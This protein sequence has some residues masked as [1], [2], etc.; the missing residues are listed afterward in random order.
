MDDLDLQILKEALEV[1]QKTTGRRAKE[2]REAL[3][4]SIKYEETR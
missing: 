2:A 3:E 1:L 4:K